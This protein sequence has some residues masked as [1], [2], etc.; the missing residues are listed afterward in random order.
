MKI[1]TTLG[2]L[3]ETIYKYRDLLLESGTIDVFEEDALIQIYLYRI[4]VPSLKL[5]F[6]S[7]DYMTKRGGEYHE[8]HDPKTGENIKID[9]PPDE[10]ADWETDMTLSILYDINE[11]DPHNYLGWSSDS[12]IGETGSYIYAQTKKTKKYEELIDIPCIIDTSEYL[13]DEEKAMKY[14]KECEKWYD[15]ENQEED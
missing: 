14:A 7:G 4:Q 12:F 3:D 2:E 6:R 5:A 1:E 15:L 13:E 9:N 8:Y 11:K 10:D